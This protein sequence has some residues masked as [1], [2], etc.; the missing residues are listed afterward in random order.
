MSRVKL[1]PLTGSLDGN[2]LR[3]Y[4]RVA[5]RRSPAVAVVSG[6][7]CLGCRVGIPPQSYIEVQ[8]GEDIISCGNCQRILIHQDHLRAP[9]DA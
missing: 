7:L 9:S 2:V 5:A 8:R 1:R 4:E 6:E 3:K